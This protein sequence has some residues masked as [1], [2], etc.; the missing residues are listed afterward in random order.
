[1]NMYLLVQQPYERWLC[2]CGVAGSYNLCMSCEG[3]NKQ[4]E[5]AEG[6]GQSEGR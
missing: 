2:G 1:M 3:E 6:G 4:M 5:G